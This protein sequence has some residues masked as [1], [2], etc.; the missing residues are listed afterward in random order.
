MGRSLNIDNL[1][2]KLYR[3]FDSPYWQE[4][5]QRCLACANCTMVCPTCFCM[6]IEDSTS[7]TGDSAERVRKWDSCF[8]VDFSYI[9]G[10]SIR[11]SEMSRYRQWLMHKLVYWQE[12]FGSPGCVGCGRCITWC[13]VGIDIAE[14]ARKVSEQK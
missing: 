1:P 4:I 11:S 9:Y 5:A 6:N 3:K 2:E 12:Q 14:E 13:P 8:N 7:L 10:G